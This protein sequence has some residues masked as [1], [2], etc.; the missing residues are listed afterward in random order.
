MTNDAPSLRQNAPAASRP[1]R[2]QILVAGA[3]AVLGGTARAKA[4]ADKTLVLGQVSLSFYA[5]TGA[6]VQKVLERI[7][8]SVVVEEGPHE[9][10][11]PLL[12]E[13]SLDL[14][15]AAW[16]PEGHARYW[17]QYGKE[18][19]E[20]AELYDGAR[21]FWAVPDYVP[22]EAV[23]SIA[24]LTKPDVAQEMTRMIQGIGPGATITAFSE[25]AIR[26]YGL[27][28][29]GYSLHHGSQKDWIDAYRNAI[30]DR[31]W[32]VFPTWTPQFLNRDGRLRA[33]EDPQGVLGKSNHASL[34]GSRSRLAGLP[35]ATATTLSRIHLGIE[36]VT[37]MDWFVNV[38]RLTP[39]TAA[40]RW[41]TANADQVERW[42]EI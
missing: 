11:F 22:P 42:F 36:A 8:Y 23:T 28:Q 39:R 15:A 41:M 29:V 1:T 31:R 5:V 14:M 30:S 6:V 38:E 9:K 34:A 37:E 35:D 12:G 10:I 7:G 40:R 3:V 18:A 19:L 20:V 32:F 17:D 4:A 2:R 26:D 33:L 21:F 16:L 24:D 25:T 27:G 13:G